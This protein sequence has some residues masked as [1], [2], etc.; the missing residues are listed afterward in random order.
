MLLNA[1]LTTISDAT[2]AMEHA[3]QTLM[4]AQAAA[5]QGVQTH[6]A[7]RS[8]AS[9][10]VYSTEQSMPTIPENQLVAD[11]RRFRYSA[12]GADSS[13]RSLPMPQ[14]LHHL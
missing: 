7:K 13:V 11:P 8:A 10:K 5:G 9:T 3:T 1:N 14:G 6:D 4:K 12:L 2:A